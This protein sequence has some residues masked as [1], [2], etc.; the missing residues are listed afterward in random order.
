MNPEEQ[1]LA[2]EVAGI[3]KNEQ[4][5][6]AIHDT[7]SEEQER[8]RRIAD[9]KSQNIAK[10]NAKQ[11]SLMVRESSQNKVNN[12]SYFPPFHFAFSL[13][14]SPSLFFVLMVSSD[15][16]RW[17]N[18]VQHQPQQHESLGGGRAHTQTPRH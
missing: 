9:K 14:L 10:Q 18:V 3:I 16:R 13:S 7:E 17:S 12:L 8:R 15:Q 5:L 1:Q 6:S 2:H 4:G 11:V